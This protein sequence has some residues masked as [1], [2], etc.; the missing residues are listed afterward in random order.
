MSWMWGWGITTLRIITG[1]IFLLNGS[2][3]L[4]I[5]EFNQIATSPLGTLGQLVGQSPQRVAILVALVE[6]LC[7]AA[8]VVGVFT[9]WASMLLAIG[10]LADILA[11]HPPPSAFLKDPGFELALLRLAASVTLVLTGSGRMA[12]DNILTSWKRR[13][14]FA[15]ACVIVMVA[16]LGF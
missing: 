6:P 2:Q 10:M 9:R 11:F 14:L 7:G 16:M 13:L 4:F 3:K 5:G 1:I 12:L 15:I 8:L